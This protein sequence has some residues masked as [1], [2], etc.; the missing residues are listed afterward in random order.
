VHR[1]TRSQS[2]FRITVAVSSEYASKD[3]CVWRRSKTLLSSQL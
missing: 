3:G 2:K 1:P